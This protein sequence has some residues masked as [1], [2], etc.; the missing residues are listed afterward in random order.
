MGD[1]FTHIKNATIF[2]RTIVMGSIGTL[3]E[4]DQNETADLLERLSVLVEQSGNPEA[5]EL[6]E[7]LSTELERPQPRKSILRSIWSGFKDVLPTV[8]Q[9]LEIAEGF[10]KLVN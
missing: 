9:M 3:R 1:K 8:P 6:L 7:G 5:G 10:G 2:N 4:R